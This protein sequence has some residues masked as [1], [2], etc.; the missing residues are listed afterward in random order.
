MAYCWKCGKPLPE[1][2]KFCIYCGAPVKIPE[3]DNIEIKPEKKQG[4]YYDQSAAKKE[5]KVEYK[6]PETAE[7]KPIKAKKSS[8]K[9][10]K[11][12]S[13]KGIGKR[14]PRQSDG[15]GKQAGK[16]ESG[17]YRKGR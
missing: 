9:G 2:A 14:R 8:R 7:E 11:D 1:D 17:K 4:L 12:G 6:F 10:E 5:E 16:T 3:T 13:Q 15:K